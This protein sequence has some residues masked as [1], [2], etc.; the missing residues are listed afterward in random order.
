MTHKET[1]YK[2]ASNK[3]KQIGGHSG[4]TDL[5]LH[6]CQSGYSRVL[7]QMIFRYYVRYIVHFSQGT[8]PDDVTTI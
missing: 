4:M 2:E 5:I 8:W 3:S 6:T 1:Q 7:A